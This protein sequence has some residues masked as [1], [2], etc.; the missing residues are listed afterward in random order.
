MKLIIVHKYYK[1]LLIIVCTYVQ[2]H[3]L[4]CIIYVQFPGGKEAGAW[5]WSLTS[6]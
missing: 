2:K 5:S 1:Q 4:Y 6:F 3:K